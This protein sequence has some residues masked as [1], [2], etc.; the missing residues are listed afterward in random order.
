[1]KNNIHANGGNVKPNYEIEL[2]WKGLKDDTFI[3]KFI[4]S[5]KTLDKLEEEYKNALSI[6]VLDQSNEKPI[7]YNFLEN[8][9][10]IKGKERG[11]V[12]VGARHYAK[13]GEVF[14]A[15]KFWNELSSKEK[16]EWLK[17]R[18]DIPTDYKSSLKYDSFQNLPDWIKE[19]VKK[20]YNDNKI[21][22]YDKGGD[23]DKWS[24]SD[25]SKAEYLGVIEFQDEQGEYHNFEIMET[26]DR[27]IFGGATNSGFI[28]SGYIEKDGMSTDD[29][30]YNLLEDLE[31]YY[32]EGED[33]TSMIVVNQRMAK[34][35][36]IKKSLA[37]FK[38][39]IGAKKFREITKGVDIKADLKHDALK[40]GRRIVRK[41][42]KTSNQYGTFKN[43]IGKVYTENR[44]NHYDANQ[45]SER[46]K[47]KL[48]DGGH[49][50]KSL[51]DSEKKMLKAQLSIIQRKF[52]YNED[53]N[54]HSE[55]VVLL[56]D[57]FGNASEKREAKRILELH[58]KEGSL[59][60]ANGLKRRELSDKLFEKWD[61]AR[62]EAG[63]FAKG[64]EVNTFDNIFEDFG[65]DK[66]RGAYGIKVF[67]NKA[68]NIYA[69][70]DS[71]RRELSVNDKDLRFS[72]LDLI[73]H[74]KSL[75]LNG[76]KY[77]EQREQMA[78]SKKFADGGNL[79]RWS[80]SAMDEII[81]KHK[82][83]T[84]Q[85]RFAF[86][87]VL[88]LDKAY[89]LLLKD[90]EGISPYSFVEKA[91]KSDLLLINEID[92]NLINSA[93]EESEDSRRFSEEGEGIG[94]SD[95]AYMIYNMLNGAGLKTEF[96]NSTLERVDNNG[97]VIHLKNELPKTTMFSDGGE[98]NEKVKYPIAYIDVLQSKPS[99]FTKVRKIL[100]K[101]GIEINNSKDF[102]TKG[103]AQELY[104][105]NYKGQKVYTI[106]CDIRD[107]SN[108]QELQK[109][110]DNLSETLFDV[111]VVYHK[112]DKDEP[113]AKGGKLSSKA[114][115][116]PKRDIAEIEIERN[117]KSKFIDG[118]NLLDGVYVRKGTKF[119][120]G[121]EVGDFEKGDLV[122][123][124]NHDWIM[125]VVGFDGNLIV[126]ENTPK[127]KM[128][129]EDSGEPIVYG[130][131]GTYSIA[132]V[133]W[134]H[135]KDNRAYAR[136]MESLRSIPYHDDD[137]YPKDYEFAKG[138]KISKQDALQKAIAMGVDFDKDFHAQSFGNELAQLAKESGYKKSP[139]S[140]GSTGRAFF[141]HLQKIY[142]G[143]KMRKATMR[144]LPK[145]DK[146]F[147]HYEVKFKKG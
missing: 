127:S 67:Y 37:E 8:K 142:D 134:A 101:Y 57:A 102:H 104:G 122:R 82:V 75:G 71:E 113:F 90:S 63:I 123:V 69:Q 99:H 130:N 85:V 52:D 26:N 25:I 137:V 2:F 135:E 33:Y 100:E 20:A 38:K 133:E 125:E 5:S 115:Y 1:M 40:Q 144:T 93:I 86:A 146:G 92:K 94:S 114:K 47:I 28:E 76:G 56:A 9:I 16:M 19:K 64:G 51:S 35:G 140:S 128:W 141:D 22:K 116:I 45:P 83:V 23:V 109:E 136:H 89:E 61:K 112:D 44:P 13:G 30:L 97:N 58:E 3:G 96:V 15:E 24:V 49:L 11:L 121:G 105:E 14:G 84:E 7:S 60:S 139:S 36:E 31:V 129:K 143:N 106:Q 147:Q 53:N 59:S 91:V 81:Q 12:Q 29:T 27:L 132:E 46:R 70:Y 77:S 65:F 43:K 138:G 34:G 62:E 110:I 120:N 117:G 48:A 111:A 4:V 88:G 95:M 131:A 79:N 126:L 50:N 32:N 39:K 72:I 103:Y 80:N 41:K 6:D 119:A 42:G 87:K 21:Y 17:K 108:S 145:D 107:A 68:N 98:L 10:Y 118:D 55:N 54:N 66:R 18:R 73:A 74:L 124:I 78:K